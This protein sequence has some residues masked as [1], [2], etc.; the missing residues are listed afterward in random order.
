VEVAVEVDAT[1]VHVLG[2]RGDASNSHSLRRSFIGITG[3]TFQS[4]SE[5]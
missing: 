1:S 3:I 2:Y 4:A 5:I